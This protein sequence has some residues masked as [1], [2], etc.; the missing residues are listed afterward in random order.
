M[1]LPQSQDDVTDVG[2][3]GL[4][5]SDIQRD[6]LSGCLC[7]TEIILAYMLPKKKIIDKYSA[8]WWYI[9]QLKTLTEEEKR[10]GIIQF[11]NDIKQ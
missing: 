6:Q 11:F 9:V 7:K 5:A 10:F 8:V 3:F 2:Y 1:T 4:G